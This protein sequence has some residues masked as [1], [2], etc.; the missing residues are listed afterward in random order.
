MIQ[1]FG[2]LKL[3]KKPFNLLFNIFGKMI[4]IKNKRMVYSFPISKHKIVELEKDLYIMTI[5]YCI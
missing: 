2:S 4:C 3:I 5:L 1:F